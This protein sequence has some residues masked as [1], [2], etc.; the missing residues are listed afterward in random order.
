MKIFQGCLGAFN[1]TLIDVI[2]PEINKAWYHTRKGIV[3]V[4]FLVACDQRMYFIYMLIGW[5]GS[6]GDAHVL[7]N[8]LRVL[9]GLVDGGTTDQVLAKLRNMNDKGR[10]GWS[11]REEKVLF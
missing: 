7:D 2:V 11:V 5:E 3:S 6:I 9:H 1:G 10:R 4:N 8:G